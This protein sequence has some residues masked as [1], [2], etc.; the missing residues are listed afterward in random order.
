MNTPFERNAAKQISISEADQST[1]TNRTRMKHL[2]LPVV[3]IG[4]KYLM[5]CSV[6]LG[7]KLIAEANQAITSIGRRGHGYQEFLFG[8]WKS[9]NK[10]S[11]DFGRNVDDKIAMN[12]SR[13][14]G[15]PHP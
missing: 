9:G 14:I 4:S 2:F 12:P 7:N 10:I 6:L 1:D 8:S 11:V 13:A 15:I 3:N 5:V